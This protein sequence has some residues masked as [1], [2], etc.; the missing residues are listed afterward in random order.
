[1]E[2][3][4]IRCVGSFITERPIIQRGHYYDFGQ[5]RRRPNIWLGDLNSAEISNAWPGED[6]NGGKD[7]NVDIVNMVWLE[8]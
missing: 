4:Q 1:M 6:Y 7:Y 5:G 2:R 3:L 8:L